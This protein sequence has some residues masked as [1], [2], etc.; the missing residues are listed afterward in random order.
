MLGGSRAASGHVQLIRLDD[1]NVHPLGNDP[2]TQDWLSFL[3]REPLAR[4]SQEEMEGDRKE[5]EENGEEE[6]KEEEKEEK[7][8]EGKD[9]KE[10][11]E[12]YFESLGEDF[13]PFI[14]PKIQ[15]VNDFLPKMMEKVFNKFPVR[16]QLLSHILLR[17][18]GKI[19]KCYSR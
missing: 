17:Q 16:F 1:K 13:R 12:E 5:E 9:E 2:M 19:E 4:V 11:G 18:A 3:E 14:L 6:E 15:L 8:E 10:V 7:D